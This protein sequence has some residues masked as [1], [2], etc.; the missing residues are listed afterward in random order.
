M[1]EVLIPTNSETGEARNW[2]DV[3]PIMAFG[4]DANE[5]QFFNEIGEAI[6]MFSRFGHETI[7]TMEDYH[8]ELTRR[9]HTAFLGLLDEN[10][11][12]IKKLPNFETNSYGKPK[13][14]EEFTPAHQELAEKRNQIYASYGKYRFMI[15]EM[16]ANL[17]YTYREHKS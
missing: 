13:N 7:K 16:F 17:G 15:D 2:H 12:E 8:I 5:W 3:F 4:T 10:L 11:A 9:I 6:A 14:E 1:P